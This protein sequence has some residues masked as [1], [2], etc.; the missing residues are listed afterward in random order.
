MVEPLRILAIGAHPDDCDYRVG[1]MAV[2]YARLGHVVKFVS[3]TNGNAGHFSQGG[4]PLAR[5]RYEEAQRSAA[6]AGIEYELFDISDAEI[7][8]TLEN[9]WTVVRTVRDFHPDLVVTNRPNDY[10]P[11]H[12]YTAQ[13]VA[14]AAYTVT[15][16]NVQSLTP[17]LDYNPVIAYWEDDFKR[18]YPFSPDVAVD[19]DDAAETK[20]DMLHCHV[21]QFYEWIPY[22]QNHLDDVPA[23]S[24]TRRAILAQQRLAAA[25]ADANDYRELLVKLYGAQRA[26]GIQY[27]EALE[28]CEYGG[29]VTPEVFA[30]LFPFFG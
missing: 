30:R 20:I 15:I 29:R 8:P 25:R 12:R 2:K 3:L 17:H 23:D 7:M 18:P 13:L 14:D 19:I 4:G 22:N 11:D 10:H 27:V 24:A 26:A 6:I 9:R 16:P 28:F 21:S 5:R 1:G